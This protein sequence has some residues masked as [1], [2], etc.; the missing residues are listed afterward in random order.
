MKIVHV[1]LGRSGPN[2]MNGV[3]KAVHFV[4]L[5]QVRLGHDVETWSLE[6]SNDKI[7]AEEHGYLNLRFP[8]TASRMLLAPALEARLHELPP[9]TWVQLHSVFVPELPGIARVL[10]NRGMAYGLTPHGGYAKRV[11]NRGK[12]KK[13]VYLSLFESAL[14]RGASLVQAVGVSEIADI[15][16]LAPGANVVLVPNGQEPIEGVTPT[17]QHAGA[18]RPVFAFCGRLDATH[19]GLDLLLDGFAEYVKSGGEGSL[20]LIGDGKHR[21]SLSAQAQRLGV[22]SRVTFHGPRFGDEKLALLAAADAFVHTS[23]WEGLPTGVLEAAALGLPLLLSR[24]TNLGDH[25]LRYGAGVVLE[26]NEP[27][28]I[29]AALAQMAQALRTDAR[30]SLQEAARRM[31]AE[32]FSWPQCAERLVTEY[33]TVLRTSGEVK[34]AGLAPRTSTV[35]DQP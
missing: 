8:V 11:L 22:A 17:T 24:E 25:T 34:A 6:R 4:A 10:R 18:A 28:P 30:E 23:R 27:S 15:R 7:P 3:S 35:T 32:E 21:G 19:K 33:Q 9:Q 12:L 26:R 20:W 16:R 31:V 2:N 5:E 14:L 29:A 1:L 13:A